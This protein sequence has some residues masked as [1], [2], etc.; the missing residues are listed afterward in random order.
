[1]KISREVKTA[2]L[3]ISG[4]VL[5]IYLFN[6]LKGENL[7]DSNV[8]YYTTFDYNALNTSS[9][10][11]IKGNTVGKISN[12]K[13]DFETGKTIVELS[14]EKG[15]KFSK[16]SKIRLYELGVMSGNALSI[17]PS[18]DNE[19]AKQGDFL[20]SETEPGLIRSLTKNFAGLS[21]GLD[22]TLKSADSLLLNL[23]QLVIDDSENGLKAVLTELNATL[24]GYKSLSNS[25]NT[26]VTKNDENITSI[27]V[28]F[29]KISEDF[30]QLSS[31]LKEANLGN[32]LTSLDQTLTSV[33]AIVSG[34]EKGEGSMGKLLKDEAL[35]NNLKGL[36]KEMEALMQDIKLHPKRYFRILSKK[37]I[38]Y[39]APQEQEN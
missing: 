36:S 17:I 22:T 10:V 27:L 26:M 14:V 15:L 20:K 3:V 33:N 1:L 4:I 18:K 7:F 24:K 28:N 16:N 9:P 6:Y 5:F 19:F 39:K 35:Y 8:T 30:T 23:N 25:I 37:E 31:Q 21:D 13:Y 29:K 2:V 34:L 12:I 11:T 38:P 32:T